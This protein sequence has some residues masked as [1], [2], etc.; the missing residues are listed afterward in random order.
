[1]SSVRSM[2]D[3]KPPRTESD[4]RTTIGAL[5]QF[6]RESLVRKLQGVDEAAA[7]SSPVGTGTS[8]LWLAKHLTRAEAT[9]VLHRFA[10]RNDPLPEDAV[11]PT[12]TVD[13]ILRAYRAMWAEV[14]EISAGSPLDAQCRDIGDD[15]NVNLRWVLMHLLEETARHAGHADILRE[16]IDGT[17]GR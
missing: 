3:Q 4:E 6:Q 12:D 8:L 5:F 10:G 9:W 15:P 17:V 7:R 11:A 2:P 1:V 13:S 14:D 16:L